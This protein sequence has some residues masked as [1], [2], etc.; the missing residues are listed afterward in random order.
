MVERGRNVSWLLRLYPQGWR[1]RYGDEV[2][3]L[4]DECAFSPWMVPWVALDLLRGAFDAHLRGAWRDQRRGIMERRLRAGEIAVF[5]AF[6][7]FGIAYTFYQRDLVDPFAPF[8]VAGQHHPE[9]L[10][11][12]DVI[13]AGAVLAFLGLVVGGAP[14]G[15]ALLSRALRERRRDLLALLAVPA[16]GGLVLVVYLALGVAGALRAVGRIAPSGPR[17]P[18]GYY[19]VAHPFAWGLILL[20][21]VVLIASTV[22]VAVAVSRVD[23]AAR[24]YRFAYFPAVVVALGMA[25]GVVGGIAWSVLLA[26]E[27]PLLFA[28]SSLGSGGLLADVALMLVAAVVAW[29]ALVRARLTRERLSVA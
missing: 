4:L 20:A 16:I 10:W 7:A 17:S 2:M 3:A 27:A 15:L 6:V 22:A 25:L 13:A 14:I 21:H 23:G 8:S 11:S 9:L 29:A 28:D 26:N 1:E 24:L 5:C 18:D 12:Y 19:P